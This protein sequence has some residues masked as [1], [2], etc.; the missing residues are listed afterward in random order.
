M[1]I[2]K[3]QFQLSTFFAV[4]CCIAVVLAGYLTSK[5]ALTIVCLFSAAALFF[6]EIV[7]ARSNRVAAIATLGIALLFGPIGIVSLFV[8]IH[9]GSLQAIRSIIFGIPIAG[10]IAI[11][12]A[13]ITNP[14]IDSLV[15][16]GVLMYLVGLMS[17]SDLLLKSFLEA[18]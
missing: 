15:V 8:A 1:M 6:A 13:W 7:L 2:R 18:V 11:A 9:Y 4:V 12:F 14:R 3:P 10:S 5:P 17:F 16:L